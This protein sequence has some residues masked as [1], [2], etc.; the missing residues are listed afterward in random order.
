MKEEQRPNKAEKQ[1][2][3]LA[4]NRFYDIFDEIRDDSF[5]TKDDWHRFSRIKEGF[6]VYSE[7]LNYT[8]IRWVIEK[9]KITRPPMEAE[10]SGELFK[11][12]R[13]V[14]SHF[15]FFDSW[16]DV[17]FNKLII[18]WYKEGQTIDRFIQK[19]VGRKV[20]KYRFWEEDKKRMTYLS[21][22]FPA[23]YQ[24]KTKI[25]LK[26]FLNEKEGVIFSFM[27]MKKIIATQVEE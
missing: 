14:I 10:I 6:A 24:E 19:Y 23:N 27:L 12:I 16:N 18:N 13:N 4:Y 21:I 26:D 25:Y 20:V 8:P 15:P 2:L 7:L 22:N 17:W 5:W 9:I 1:F 11:F 3:T